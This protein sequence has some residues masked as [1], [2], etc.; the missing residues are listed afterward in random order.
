MGQESWENLGILPR[1][2][3]NSQADLK[4]SSHIYLAGKCEVRFFYISFSQGE[5][6]PPSAYLMSVSL[7]RYAN[8]D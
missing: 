7:D 3:V 2:R 6:I 8:E 1:T 4:N 5:A